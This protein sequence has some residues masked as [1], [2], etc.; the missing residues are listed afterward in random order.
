M[1][2]YVELFIDQG[3]TFKNTINLTDDTTNVA[4]NVYGYSVSSQIRRSYYSANISAN[5]TCNISNVSNGE[6]T[7]SMTSANTTNIKAGRY[8]FDVVTLDPLNVKTRVLEG[9]I[10]INPQ[11]TK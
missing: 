1:A 7:M 9:I 2:S 11:V 3:T 10:S 6:I 8:V 4:I 5:I